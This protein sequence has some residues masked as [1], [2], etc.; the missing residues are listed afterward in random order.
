M[1]EG[2]RRQSR[3][4]RAGK[5]G[6]KAVKADT[7]LEKAKRREA[8]K[9]TL[10]QKFELEQKALK[11][12]ERL[13]DDEVEDD[14]LIDCA[15]FITSANYKDTVEERSIAKMCGYPVCSNKLENVPKQQYKISTKTNKVYDITERKCFCSNF[16]YKASKHYEVQISKTPLWLREE[17]S[18]SSGE[19]V[20]ISD[21]PISESE[22]ENPEPVSCRDSAASDSESSDPE[23]DFVSSVVTGEVGPGHRAQTPKSRGKREKNTAK[24][25]AEWRDPERDR[26]TTQQ[27]PSTRGTADK[28]REKLQQSNAKIDQG[29]NSGQHEETDRP[30]Q[31]LEATTDL[32]SSCRIEEGDTHANRSVKQPHADSTPET[33]LNITQ[34]GMSR[35]GAAELRNLLNTLGPGGA[36][37]PEKDPTSTV[38]ARLL[39]RLSQTLKDWRTEETLVFLYG[40]GYRPEED[41]GEKEELDEDDLEDSVERP[42]TAGTS[43]GQQGRPSAPAPDYDSLRKETELLNLKVQEFFRGTYV[44]PEEERDTEDNSGK[45]PALPLVDSHA[46]HLIQKRI[47]SEKLNR[48]L[49]DVVGPLRL[50]M[51]DIASDLN[52]LIRTFRF[53][54]S[55]IIH[56]S[57]EWTLIAVVLL[58]VLSKVSPVLQ[59]SL[60]RPCSI[61]YISTLMRELMLEDQDLLSLVHLFRGQAN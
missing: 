36:S 60:E 35:R 50:A 40:P 61:E 11:I 43:R 6:G 42:V 4:P 56:K 48:S 15:R 23:Q 58:S 41:E 13:L 5:K 9:E 19:E 46:Q 53:T 32:L 57:P 51:N 26:D 30:E 10:R 31:T 28:E 59:E 34:V 22:I 25:C 54:N 2:Q 38:R 8:L 27:Q 20:K 3:P 17:E 1:E 37:G 18:G 49:R 33:G 21:R 39:Q 14:F 29:T 7:A 16:C 12:V 45:D 52:N 24:E 47:V 44:L 55:N